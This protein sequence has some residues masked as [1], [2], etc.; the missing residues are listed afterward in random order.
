MKMAADPAPF[1]GRAEPMTEPRTLYRS[2]SLPELADILRTGRITGGGNRF[3]EADRRP[4]VL[5]ADELDAY[6][7][8]QGEDTYRQAYR[9]ADTAPLDAAEAEIRAHGEALLA[10]L[11]IDGIWLD[12]EKALLFP[13]GE[14]YGRARHVALRRPNVR[15]KYRAL[16]KQLRRL[17]GAHARLQERLRHQ[18]AHLQ[19]DMVAER[20]AL[21]ISSA[22]LVTRPVARGLQFVAE[23]NGR[24]QGLGGREYGFQPGELSVADIAQI[25]LIK[26][27]AESARISVSPNG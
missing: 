22:V 12:P 26:D 15:L 2:V 10:E 18:I 13:F 1:Y 4:L 19:A 8:R 5:F 17:K 25:I 9:V 23:W 27:G 24:V 16:F 3:N 14:G 20:Q 21:P 6:V 7:I 11:E